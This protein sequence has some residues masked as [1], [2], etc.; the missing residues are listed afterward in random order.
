[1]NLDLAPDALH[2]N[3]EGYRRWVEVITRWWIGVRLRR[4]VDGPVEREGLGTPPDRIL[5]RGSGLV[6]Q[7]RTPAPD[8]LR[9]QLLE[10]VT[11]SRREAEAGVDDAPLPV[12]RRAAHVQRAAAVHGDVA[13]LRRAAGCAA[14]RDRAARRPAARWRGASR[15][16]RRARRCVASAPVTEIP[17]VRPQQPRE[18]PPM[19]AVLVP[20]HVGD[21]FDDAD[22][23][24]QPFGAVA[25]SRRPLHHRV[26]GERADAPEPVATRAA[27]A[28]SATSG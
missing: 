19:R 23:L 1:M 28:A 2:P 27:P 3:A 15:R 13:G 11:G 25:S 10:H 18:W 21:A 5:A 20:R 8:L 22:L 9:A 12:D 17:T 4:F 7:R 16:R 26:V 24:Q 6:A 14:G